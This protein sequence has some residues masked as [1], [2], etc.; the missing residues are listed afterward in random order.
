MAGQIVS[1]LMMF[2]QN[3][4]KTP[5]P[6]NAEKWFI[7]HRHVYMLLHPYRCYVSY[8]LDHVLYCNCFILMQVRAVGWLLCDIEY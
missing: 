1:S 6:V 5:L 7:L 3:R 2:L 4:Q 8:A